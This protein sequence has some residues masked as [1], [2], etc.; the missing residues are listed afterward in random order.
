[1]AILAEKANKTQIQGFRK[2]IDEILWYSFRG[3]TS[4][5]G[6]EQ[7]SSTIGIAVVAAVRMLKG[8][9]QP[10]SFTDDLNSIVFSKTKKLQVLESRLYAAT[11][12][13]QSMSY[14]ELFDVLRIYREHGLEY[15]VD[16]ILA[17][18]IPI[19][20]KPSIVPCF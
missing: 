8:D 12:K 18:N 15:T 3:K 6:I 5:T 20:I 16:Y 17:E 2:V 13:I 10:G 9:Y 11:A 19:E 1:M 7:G 14:K 4:D